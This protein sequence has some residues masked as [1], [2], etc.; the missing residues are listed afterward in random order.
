VE[1]RMIDR[2]DVSEAM[3]RGN[4]KREGWSTVGRSYQ[5]VIG[6]ELLG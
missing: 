4:C 2:S 1:A 5:Y 3:E 6:L